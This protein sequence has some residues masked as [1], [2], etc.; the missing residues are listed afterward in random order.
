ML[1]CPLNQEKVYC[2][3][4][5]AQEVKVC[6]G[7]LV[8]KTFN[9]K[10]YCCPFFA[11]AIAPMK[12]CVLQTADESVQLLYQVNYELMKNLE[13]AQADLVK[14]KTLDYDGLKTFTTYKDKYLALKDMS[15]DNITA[16]KSSVNVGDLSTSISSLN[17]TTS[18]LSKA[19]CGDTSG[20]MCVQEPSWGLADGVS[21]IK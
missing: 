5:A 18:K 17:R 10:K 7:S 13:V 21:T 3:G 15:A 20:M 1:K 16:L 4:D 14:F 12:N 8:E 11:L 9:N 19:A 2:G 6:V